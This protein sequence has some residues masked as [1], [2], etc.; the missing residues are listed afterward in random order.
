MLPVPVLATGDAT[1]VAASLALIRTIARMKSA[2]I[3]VVTDRIRHDRQDEITKVWGTTFI[4][5]GSKELNE[6]FLRADDDEARTVVE[7]WKREASRVVEP[8]DRDLMESARLYLAIRQMKADFQADAVTIDCLS[9]SYGQAYEEHR[10][11]Y[12]CMAFYT[13]NCDGETAVCEADV[14]ATATALLTLYLTGR[15]GFVSDPVIDTASNQIIYCHCVA[16]PKVFGT[17][18]KRTCRFSI[19]SHAEDRRGASVQ[20]IFPENQKLTTAMLLSPEHR[21]AIHSA[22]SVGNVGGEEA[23]RSKLAA[24]TNAEQILENWPA[25]QWHRVTVFGEYRK[26]FLQLFRMVDLGVVEEDLK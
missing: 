18:D 21:A 4:D 5:Q 25:N 22:V 20:V 10:H 6:Y 24:T 7:R 2:R 26:A 17:S 14:N 16:C 23:C 15:P 19:R 11:M 3:L 8:S 12:P 9:L 1:E 13:L